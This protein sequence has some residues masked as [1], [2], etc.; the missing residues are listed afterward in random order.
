M[1]LLRTAALAAGVA[2]ALGG[3]TA[4]S[5]GG[6]ATTATTSASPSPNAQQVAAL[7][8]QLA[9]CL[10]ENGAPNF[11]DPVRDARTG[12]WVP[13]RGTKDPPQRAFTACRSISDR[14]PRPKG[15]EDRPPTAAELAKL[16]QFST[17]MREQ[18]SRDWPDPNSD[19][20]FPLPERLQ[21]LGKKAFMKELQACRHLMP[22]TYPGIRVQGDAKG[23]GSNGK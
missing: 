20:R 18:G 8:R 13:P 2:V 14:I 6:A 4:C 10:R 9:Q 3:L 11:P 17:C 15:K 5:T 7:Y 23:K 21:R 1:P 19:G 12:E 16:R 22:K